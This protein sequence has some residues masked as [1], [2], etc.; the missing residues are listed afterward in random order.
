MKIPLFDIDSTL[1]KGGNSAHGKAFSYAIKMI[2]KIN[3]SEDEIKSSG[4]IDTQILI[5]ILKLHNFTEE[6]AKKKIDQAIRA[7]EVYYHKHKNDGQ[8]I[9]LKGVSKLLKELKDKKIPVGLL[10]GNVESIGWDKLERAGIREYFSF[11]AFGSLA[12]KRSDLVPIAKKRAE[13]ILNKKLS[14]K[15]FFIV[16]DSPL[17]V[18][19]AQEAGIR[20][21]AVS[22]GR[23]SHEQLSNYKPDLVLKSLEEKDKFFEFLQ[24]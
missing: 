7:M 21:V 17:D 10:T 22:S 1:L 14:T 18:A 24:S 16:G 5:E 15:D 19:C 6:K 13:K 8:C 23:F 2:Y 3:A 20:V 9:I 12:F 4:M 11:G